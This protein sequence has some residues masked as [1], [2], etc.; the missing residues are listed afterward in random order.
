MAVSLYSTATYWFTASTSF[1]NP[2][3]AVV[4]I[5]MFRGSHIGRSA[6]RASANRQL[7]DQLH[8]IAR[9]LFQ[10]ALTPERTTP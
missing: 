3:V 10:P 8:I 2:A 1:A 4:A 6:F 5:P 9:A 7:V